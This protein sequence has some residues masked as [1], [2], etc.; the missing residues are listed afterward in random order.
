MAFD[1]GVPS[2]AITLSTTTRVPRSGPAPEA[3]DGRDRRRGPGENGGG[4]LQTGSQGGN[5]RPSARFR[6]RR[7]ERDIS[8]GP[9]FERGVR[10]G[11][12]AG[13]GAG[14]RVIAAPR[15]TSTTAGRPPS[16]GVRLSNSLVAA[17][18][19]APRGV[20]RRN[21]K[22]PVRP[23]A[24]TG[25]WFDPRGEAGSQPVATPPVPDAGRRSRREGRP[26]AS[27]DADARYAN[28]RIA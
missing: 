13:A 26:A 3:G 25:P 21:E 14:S 10:R 7:V 19:D 16:R 15:P 17:L 28:P 22:S 24:R 12:R 11:R 20:A 6:G 1:K 4:I 2:S 9:H 23:V 27:V 8:P 18:A 5:P